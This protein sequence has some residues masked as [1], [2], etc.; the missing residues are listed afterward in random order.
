MYKKWNRRNNRIMLLVVLLL[1][2]SLGYAALSTTLKINGTT[3]LNKNSWSVYFENVANQKGVTTTT[4]TIDDDTDGTED[5]VVTWT[6]D[7][8]TPGDYY[9]FTVDIVNA[10]SID[11]MITAITQTL[12]GQPITEENKLPDY[13]IYSVTY[14]DGKEIAL[15]QLLEKADDSEHP[16]KDTLKI[17][18]E[19]SRSVTN[20]EV[21]DQE[22]TLTYTMSY[23][24]KFGQAD[25]NAVEVRYPCP[26]PKCV[27]A[28]YTEEKNYAENAST[29]TGY[30][31]DYT[32]LLDEND[33][34]RKVFLGHRLDKDGKIARGFA[35]GIKDDNVYCIEGTADGSQYSK[36][37]AIAHTVALRIP[38]Q[39]TNNYFLSCEGY[40]DKNL[41]VNVSGERC[42]YDTDGSL[43]VNNNGLA[44]ITYDGK[45]CSVN[46]NGKMNC[47]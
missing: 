16:T 40:A 8:N 45:T 47:N 12:N 21:N 46:T 39:N 5:A 18:I 11:A 32:E 38:V 30:T 44:K 17:R 36:N 37:T 19:Y 13:I 34:P 26:G 33:E 28:Y 20:T 24:L 1:A 31:S 27:Y 15:N 22:D 43:D 7:L 35:C 42:N 23:G 25:E 14:S 3:T 9:E 2:V 41:W 4:P 10:G 29:L 6:V